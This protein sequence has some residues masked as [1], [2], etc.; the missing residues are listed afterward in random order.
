MTW[1]DEVRTCACGERFKP[2]RTVARLFGVQAVADVAK[3]GATTS[4][5]LHRCQE[6]ACRTLPELAE[7][8]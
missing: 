7:A 8:A 1:K 5:V 3:K 6:G 4:H 2:K